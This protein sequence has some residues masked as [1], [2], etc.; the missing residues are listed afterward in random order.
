MAKYGFK[1]TSQDLL[2]KFLFWIRYHRKKQWNFIN[3]L[4]QQEEIAIVQYCQF[5]F[6]EI[7]KDSDQFNPDNIQDFSQISDFLSND[8]GENL[9]QLINFSCATNFR[10]QGKIRRFNL[11]D[12]STF[13]L[14]NFDTAITDTDSV[15]FIL[16]QMY[17]Y[18]TR[19]DQNKLMTSL[20][21]ILKLVNYNPKQ[22]SDG[23]ALLQ[24]FKILGVEN[25]D[26]VD[27]DPASRFNFMYDSLSEQG[28]HMFLDREN[29][30]NVYKSEPLV[31]LHLVQLYQRSADADFKPLPEQI[32]I[33]AD[34]MM[35]ALLFCQAFYIKDEKVFNIP[36]ITTQVNIDV[37][38]KSVGVKQVWQF[39]DDFGDIYILHS[40]DAQLK[41]E[42]PEE[43]ERHEVNS[44]GIRHP[45]FSI[46]EIKQ[47]SIVASRPIKIQN[48]D[49]KTVGL[50]L[51]LD[52]FH[53]SFSSDLN[54]LQ[55][56]LNIVC[57]Y[58]I[59]QIRI[60][61]T[62][63]DAYDS[64]SKKLEM[65]TD[66][67]T[68][69]ID[70]TKTPRSASEELLYS[71]LGYFSI[72]NFEV[73][74]IKK[75]E[76]FGDLGEELTGTVKMIFYYNSEYNYPI[77]YYFPKE[78]I[79]VKEDGIFCNFRTKKQED[80]NS[81]YLELGTLKARTEHELRFNVRIPTEKIEDDLV[82]DFPITSLIDIQPK[83][84]VSVENK[85]ITITEFPDT[86]Y[87]RIAVPLKFDPNTQL[88]AD[89]FSQ[90]S[91][92]AP[93]FIRK[94]S[95]YPVDVIET[96]MDL[97]LDSGLLTVTKKMKFDA[98]YEKEIFILTDNKKGDEEVNIT[99]EKK[100][101][102]KFSFSL[103]RFDVKEVLFLEDRDFRAFTIGKRNPNEEFI[104]YGEKTIKIDSS[105]VHSL[106][107]QILLDSFKEFQPIPFTLT[108]TSKTYAM[109]SLLYNGKEFKCSEQNSFQQAINGTQPSIEFTV[110]KVV[111]AIDSHF[112]SIGNGYI[113]IADFKP[114]PFTRV[115]FRGTFDD[116]TEILKGQCKLI[117]ATPPFVNPLIYHP[118]I[119][120]TVS[121]F[122]SDSTKL[123]KNKNNEYPIVLAE[124]NNEHEIVFDLELKS[125]R[126]EDNWLVS[127]PLT[128]FKHHGKPSL[129][130]FID[131]KMQKPIDTFPSS[132]ELV[133]P[134]AYDILP[135]LFLQNWENCYLN[136]NTFIAVYFDHKELKACNF[137]P[138][139]VDIDIK[140][141][142]MQFTKTFT[143]H[144]KEKKAIYILVNR[145]VSISWIHKKEKIDIPDFPFDAYTIG[146]YKSGKEIQIVGSKHFDINNQSISKI[147]F[148]VEFDILKNS[149]M[150]SVITVNSNFKMKYLKYLDEEIETKGNTATFNSLIKEAQSEMTVYKVKPKFF[151]ELRVKD[152]GFFTLDKF[153]LLRIK[154]ISVNGNIDYRTI[155]GQIE[156]TTEPNQYTEEVYYHIPISTKIKLTSLVVDNENVDIKGDYI[157]TVDT[158]GNQS[159]N[160][161]MRIIKIGHLDNSSDHLIKFDFLYKVK[162]RD[163][164]YEIEF[165]ITKYQTLENPEFEFK[166]D[167]LNLSINK[168]PETKV[169]IITKI[170]N[171]PFLLFTDYQKTFSS[172]HFGYAVCLYQTR[173]LPCNETEVPVLSVNFQ[174]KKLTLQRTLQIPLETK[175]K[176]YVIV[177]KDNTVTGHFKFINM[178]I[179]NLPFDVYSIGEQIAT[180]QLNF[181]F[182]QDFEYIENSMKLRTF[183]IKHDQFTSNYRTYSLNKLKFDM[184]ISGVKRLQVDGAEIKLKEGVTRFNKSLH[185]T[186]EENLISLTYGRQKISDKLDLVGL[187]YFT[188]DVEFSLLHIQDI[189]IQCNLVNDQLQG[190]IQYFLDD[191]NFKEDN[192]FHILGNSRLQLSDLRV[193][194]TPKEL[195]MVE[196]QFKKREMLINIGSFP[197]IDD[198]NNTQKRRVQFKF[199]YSLPINGEDFV[200]DFPLTRFKSPDNNPSTFLFEIVNESIRVEKLPTTHNV[201]HYEFPIEN[202]PEEILMDYENLFEYVPIS[203]MCFFY[204]QRPIV[205]T[206]M[207]SKVVVLVDSKEIRR[208]K[209]FHFGKEYGPRE[210]FILVSKES[211][212]IEP[213]DTEI[214]EAPELPFNLL[215]CSKIEPDTTITLITSE[216]IDI[217]QTSA[218]ELSFTLSNDIELSQFAT[219]DIQFETIQIQTDVEIARITKNLNPVEFNAEQKEFQIEPNEK[220]M[221]FVIHQDLIKQFEKKFTH[222]DLGYF[223]LSDSELLPIKTIRVIC[224]FNLG[225][226][227]GAIQF[228][229]GQGKS[230]G[231]VYYH[232]PQTL[233]L[234]ELIVDSESLEMNLINDNLL[235]IGKFG[236][237]KESHTVRFSF[238]QES[239]INGNKWENSFPI[240]RY[241]EDEGEIRFDFEIRNQ[242]M[243][244][245]TMPA[246]PII[247]DFPIPNDM[248]FL[249]Q[250]LEKTDIFVSAYYLSE[251][252]L[253]AV[254]IV[255]TEYAV[256]IEEKIVQFLRVFNLPE[257]I[258]NSEVALILSEK[259]QYLNSTVPTNNI[260]I[261]GLDAYSAGTLNSTESFSFTF[262]VPLEIKEETM[263]SVSA[264]FSNDS[265]T[266]SPITVNSPF[267]MDTVS[268]IFADENDQIKQK[269]KNTN[270]IKIDQ[271][272]LPKGEITM[273]IQKSKRTFDDQ[274]KCANL[275]Y[276][277]AEDYEFLPI[278]KIIASGKFRHSLKFDVTFIIVNPFDSNIIAYYHPPEFVKK[279]K[280]DN[281][282]EGK[283]KK[284]RQHINCGEFE[285]GDT[286]HE[287]SFR[288]QLD[289]V[290]NM[291]LFPLT[292]YAKIPNPEFLFEIP[293]SDIKIDTMPEDDVLA[294]SLSD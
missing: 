43:V 24:F 22:F 34:E 171:D 190:E 274:L 199:T 100:Q 167:N 152:L 141:K 272:G 108:I 174:D 44:I 173:V 207:S 264:S 13:F 157:E 40:N 285:P 6:N 48:K 91:M 263:K 193:D 282:L 57:P 161:E 182:C 221:T 175:Q 90:I 121:N 132:N 146:M 197:K 185:V 29:F 148:N 28:I 54:Y 234:S 8:K 31:M 216:T 281:E 268:F 135:S 42:D 76:F 126:D 247:T 275:G 228:K 214:I 143:H 180:K 61:E 279:V 189:C 18:K 294:F 113:S 179:E 290:D 213:L 195:E 231:D 184:D 77:F 248:K 116:E 95:I 215:K 192:Y 120:S 104:V 212:I 269:A 20:R 280:I 220:D 202:I 119:D 2:K 115:E 251:S 151:D 149:E 258:E 73:C 80:E 49:V 261:E 241:D 198:P 288:M 284:N 15:L 233:Q 58:K 33:G 93:V 46:G 19:D 64:P 127:F 122:Q 172:I 177:P 183:P 186:Q 11:I 270:S 205:L 118:N 92:F 169:K 236:K 144:S 51:R 150:N 47:F 110:M 14:D 204:L 168:L 63:F 117:F 71:G 82:A 238:K 276:F 105:D 243:K 21:L 36:P 166:I 255:K 139:Q 7:Y 102:S 52:N 125:E 229:I 191:V 293:K 277:T 159:T 203:Q 253:K 145:D 178:N 200:L 78:P 112:Y 260:N 99:T 72:N 59:S 111:E 271:I 85:D 230:K 222:K 5:A 226:L 87:V 210:V 153:N 164:D 25:T 10:I 292:Q 287:I 245:S 170:N 266:K 27:S 256:N 158:K 154:K 278:K 187:G 211:T 98:P 128:R 262:S 240:T 129:Y 70:I 267:E 259:V 56:D 60:D 75:I 257:D 9:I 97:D 188:V 30:R 65:R 217:D 79:I 134:V 163:V 96:N 252:E 142:T 23:S 219:P 41:F 237:N 283:L 17:I 74:D 218:S 107:F 254:P 138:I 194:S 55:F 32:I 137:H 103:F 181:T 291:F 239:V 265:E 83:I 147:S 86:N 208:E 131:N 38:S 16:M 223:T 176:V 235:N 224:D 123:K 196:N 88:N 4:N 89:L 3:M 53:S 124:G 156:F 39:D 66:N 273:F 67:K 37:S 130:F 165:P 162:L 133:V 109:R 209:V 242:G 246:S 140:K 250:R 81:P 84:N 244:Y 227:E 114:Y 136:L 69:D 249:L 225:V 50:T 101:N 45:V 62:E 155:N 206:L 1:F 286:E 106:K 68:I 232:M 35:K 160:E 201:L 289:P 12:P 94:Q 26:Q